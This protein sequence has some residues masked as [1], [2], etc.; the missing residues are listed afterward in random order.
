MGRSIETESTLVDAEGWELTGS[1]C[2]VPSW[3]DEKVLKSGVAAALLC[4]Y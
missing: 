2:M 4:L 3:G 1:E